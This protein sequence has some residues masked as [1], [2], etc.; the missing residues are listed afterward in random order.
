MKKDKT[1]KLKLGYKGDVKEVEITLPDDEPRPFDMT[2]KL[3]IMGK[4]HQKVDAVMKVTGRAK[5]THD[6][7]PAGMLFGGFV[8]CPHAKAN[9]Q[10]IDMDK[11]AKSPGVKAVVDAE[12]LRMP[13][14]I[15]YA[16]QPVAALAAESR[17][18]LE[19]AI[20][21]AD[22]SYEVLPHAARVDQATAAD[23]PQVHGNRGNVRAGRDPRQLAEVNAALNSGKLKVAEVVART[24][25]QTHSCLET[26]GT[27]AQWNGEHLTIWTSTQATFG[28]RGQLAR[29]L[30]VSESNITVIGEFMGGGFGSKFGAGYWSLAA[31]RLA[32][33]AGAPVKIMLDRRED[34]TDTGNRPD[35][36]QDMKM[37]V[38]GDGKIAAYS[39]SNT[40]TPGIGRGASVTNPMIYD[41][42]RDMTASR[43][44]EVAT[45]AGG[46]QAFR[47][48]GHP[49]GSFGL[50]TV[51]D[52]A[53][54]KAGIDPVEFR[55][56]NDSNFVRQQQYKEGA[57]KI[58]W[59]DR[60]KN[61]AATGRFRTGYGV[62]AAKWGGTGGPR[63][64]V[65][66]RITNDGS[67]EVRNGA[68]DLGVG[69][70]TLLAVVAGEELGIDPSQIKTAIG[71]TNDPIGPG[72]GGSRTAASIAP[73]ARQAAFLVGR[74]LK[75]LVA[76]HLNCEA[77]DLVTKGGK[78]SSLTDG[79]KSMSF[80]DACRLIRQGD[81]SAVGK[82]VRNWRDATYM[83][84]VAGAQFAKVTVDCDFGIV[85][86]DKLVA[87]QDCGLVINR[88]TAEGQVFGGMI[89]GLSYA[90]FEERHMDRHLGHMINSDLEMYKIAGPADMPEMEVVLYDVANGA[91]NCSVAGIGEP[92]MIPTAA[93]IAGAVHNATGVRVTSIPMTPD[94]VLMALEE[95]G[96]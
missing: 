88:L 16:G 10:S 1:H 93:A 81:I 70:R 2:S 3:D 80:K 23:A 75:A 44:G 28:V 31:A 4:R 18:A 20:R 48:P 77:D 15:R 54:E 58:G 82:R 21:N 65:L 26:H 91:N 41:I 63:A 38:D 84:G 42:P 33:K 79:K 74:E 11:L 50:E 40:G 24:Q 76:Q 55:L 9:L 87:L 36:I 47:A 51:M 7:K 14:T 43:R 37:G 39:V 5:Y 59:A 90:L 72:S 71:N 86:V 19:E 52:L 30:G 96:K 49:Q 89:Q 66:C 57:K 32:K 53:A 83:N 61:G 92:T 46:A 56:R 64:E 62:A 25:V 22:V 73:A 35:S 68:Q 17:Q 45:N 34:Q 85:K 78:V 27:A 13:T 69:T 95:G 94:K 60:K 29:G 6:M 8:R 12:T 67:I